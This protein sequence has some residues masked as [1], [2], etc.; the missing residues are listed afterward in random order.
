MT[1]TSPA[2]QPLFLRPLD[3]WLFRDGKPFNAGDD[4]SAQS[5]FPPLPTVI[6]GAIR[7]HHLVM[8]TVP[9][10]D[11]AKIV[12]EIGTATDYKQLHLRGPFVRKGNALYFPLPA[13]VYC[14]DEKTH[15]FRALNASTPNVAS[16]AAAAL[17]LLPPKG[18]E[19]KKFAAESLWVSQR[20][21]AKYLAGESFVATQAKCLFQHEPRTGI[22]MDSARRVTE[23]GKLFEVN[24]V[25]PCEG[26]G[27]HVEMAGLDGWEKV[28]GLMRI[29]GEGRAATV[30]VEKLAHSVPAPEIK[31]GL[32]R[33]K[34]VLLTPTY[35]AGGWQPHDWSAHFTGS[36]TLKAAA[37]HK[38]LS[39]GGYDWTKPKDGHKP[40]LRYVPA[41]S[42]YYFEAETN[43]QLK[44][45]W[46]CDP[47]P[48]NAQL[49]Q[50]GFG[51]VTVGAWELHP[52]TQEH[53]HV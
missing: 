36:V 53:T 30:N 4:H 23:D 50:I 31:P 10:N 14:T 7:S 39:V 47:S 3:V 35:F 20:E 8:R 37:L 29:G 38:Y 45:G 6:Q 25:R 46:L 24:Y 44:S 28:S 33:F 1:T 34:L 21:W 19:P 18:A 49:G 15:A 27:L 43:V 16:N 11:P 2:T 17:L 12:N 32:R 5:L 26:V 40:A 9:L 42:V 52:H 13:D 51:Q 22:Q 48:D 41:G